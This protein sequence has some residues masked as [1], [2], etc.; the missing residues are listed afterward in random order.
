MK[1]Y[2]IVVS[3]TS[4]CE[5][6]TLNF[7]PELAKHQDMWAD[8]LVVSFD[9]GWGVG[10]EMWGSVEGEAETLHCIQNEQGIEL[11]RG[12]SGGER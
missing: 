1:W 10:I 7:H 9:Q 6:F 12:T 11:S 3:V 5:K 8:P 2:L 4:Y